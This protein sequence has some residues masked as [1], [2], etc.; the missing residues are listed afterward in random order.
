[1][2][3][4]VDTF[5]RENSLRRIIKY[6]CDTSVNQ[7]VDPVTETLCMMLTTPLQFSITEIGVTFFK[8]KNTHVFPYCN[9][10]R[11]QIDYVKD[12]VKRLYGVA[13]VEESARMGVQMGG[14]CVV[15]LS[16]SS[17]SA[18]C[19]DSPQQQGQTGGGGGA[20][21]AEQPHPEILDAFE[22]L[23]AFCTSVFA[24]KN[25]ASDPQLCYNVCNVV[26]QRVCGSVH[27]QKDVQ[28]RLFDWCSALRDM[29]TAAAQ[30]GGREAAG[31]SAV[32]ALSLIHI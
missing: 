11:R 19:E 15:K 31:G 22:V 14:G 9:M 21:E 12:T 30:N 18:L 26:I 27:L 16:S 10:T 8:D 5:L 25:Y 6:F 2:R 28:R 7:V 32:S 24:S 3:E 4:V 29:K 1:M 13:S 17:S 20:E 23:G